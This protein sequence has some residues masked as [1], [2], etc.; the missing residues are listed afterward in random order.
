MTVAEYYSN[1]VKN[2]L[3]GRE[4]CRELVD[5]QKRAF[6]QACNSIK[7]NNSTFQFIPDGKSTKAD[8]IV[9]NQWY[10]GMVAKRLFCGTIDVTLFFD[11]YGKATCAYAGILNDLNS[12]AKVSTFLEITERL[13]AAMNKAMEQLVEEATNN[14]TNNT[15][16]FIMKQSDTCFVFGDV[17]SDYYDHYVACVKTIDLTKYSDQFIN[18]TLSRYFKG[19][20]ILNS[21]DKLQ[22][23]FEEKTNQVVAHMIFKQTLLSDMDFKSEPFAFETC[24]K[25]TLDFLMKKAT[26]GILPEDSSKEPEWTD[27]DK[28]CM[29]HKISDT[30]FYYGEVREETRFN[31]RY[32]VVCA[33]R[34]N[35]D[36]YSEEGIEDIVK[37]FYP[38]GIAEVKETYKDRANQILAECIFEMTP[39]SEMEYVRGLYRS[40]DDAAKEL[41]A[42]VKIEAE[43]FKL[44]SKQ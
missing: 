38:G 43:H 21:L 32:Y 34:I 36:D 4:D 10:Y 16:C 41:A 23:I 9:T 6:T 3:D 7:I 14:E 13:R 28:Q 25:R 40:E 29:I 2:V 8:E 37:S 18:E 44:S 22:G 27:D 24:A 5:L 17:R 35:L 11:M 19:V 12:M 20:D 42:F 30:C 31:G 1:K 39:T 15:S 33:R 26:D